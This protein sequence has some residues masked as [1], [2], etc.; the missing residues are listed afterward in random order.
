MTIDLPT[1]ATTSAGFVLVLL[2]KA[3][4]DFNLAPIL[5][6]YLH[7]LPVRN[8][9]RSKPPSLAGQWEMNWETDSPNFASA[10]DKHDH[11]VILQLDRYC[12]ADFVSKQKRYAFFGRIKGAYVVGD[13]YDQSDPHG[14]YGTFQLRIVDSGHLAGRYIGHSKRDGIVGGGEWKWTKLAK[15]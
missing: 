5:V 8:F 2:L 1:V 3:L 15:P 11:P 6:K 7:R 9:F 10:T 4:L 12:Y 13:W 14:Y